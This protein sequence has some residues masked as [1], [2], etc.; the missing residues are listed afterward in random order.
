MAR[1]T[2]TPLVKTN[3]LNRKTA[4]VG[5]LVIVGGTFAMLTIPKLLLAPYLQS[6]FITAGTTPPVQASTSLSFPIGVNPKTKTVSESP[7][8]AHYIGTIVASNHTSPSLAQNW[9]TKLAAKFADSDWFQNLASP[10]SRLLVIQSGERQ[11][12]ITSHFAHI[13]GWTE[14]EKEIFRTR[15]ASEVPELP[16][17]KLYPGN[18]VVEKGANPDTVATAVADKFDSEVRAH[19][20]EDIEAVVPL[21]DTLILASLLEREAYD[22][23]DMR[24]ISGIIWNRLFINMRLQIDATMQYAKAS[25]LK[26]PGINDWWPTPLPADK[27]ID[28]PYNTYK[29]AGLPPAPIANPSIDAIIAALNPRK[30]DCLFYF[31]DRNGKFYCTKTYEEH[32]ALLKQVYG[33]KAK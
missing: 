9:F 19:Y 29:N 17:G 25:K 14:A 31:H 15:L 1:I 32:V 13:L 12:E 20:T 33:N 4:L 3:R 26:N 24:Y 11:E 16:D 18:Y 8:I 23:E 10:I 27:F 2:P 5:G 22:F 28:S 6:E 21:K 7:F 30:T